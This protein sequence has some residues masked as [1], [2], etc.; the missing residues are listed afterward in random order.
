M[1][2]PIFLSSFEKFH[3]QVLG[4]LE[5]TPESVSV[6]EDEITDLETKLERVNKKRKVKTFQVV[7]DEVT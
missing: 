4:I 1:I 7:I 6:V 3:D 2:D 5:D